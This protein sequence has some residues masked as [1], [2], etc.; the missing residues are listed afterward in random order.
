M[1]KRKIISLLIL[2]IALSVIGIATN[3]VH[4]IILALLGIIG[5]L[6]VLCIISYLVMIFITILATNFI[7]KNLLNNLQYIKQIYKAK[8]KAHFTYDGEDL[9][10]NL[11][12]YDKLLASHY[13]DNEYYINFLIEHKKYLSKNKYEY[14]LKLANNEI[15]EEGVL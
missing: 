15:R 6:S 4:I 7:Y 3:T 13:S 5:V 2:S 9:K 12:L 10:K 11:Y 8:Y 14:V 1:E